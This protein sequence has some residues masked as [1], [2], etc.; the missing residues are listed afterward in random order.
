[1]MEDNSKTLHLVLDKVD[2]LER[3]AHIPNGEATA[4]I[5]GTVPQSIYERY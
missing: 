3:Q 4:G 2:R 1:M 5:A